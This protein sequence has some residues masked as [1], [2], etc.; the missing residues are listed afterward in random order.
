MG[1]NDNALVPQDTE[2]GLIS[3]MAAFSGLELM[4]EYRGSGLILGLEGLSPSD[5]KLPRFRIMQPTSQEVA[6][7]KVQAGTF[8]NPV[9]GEAV[10]EL[11]CT[12]LINSKS[13]VM[14]EKLFKRGDKPMCS[15]FD[16][17][18]SSDG[19]RKC[20]KCNS[21]NGTTKVKETLSHHVIC[22]MYGLE[23][24]NFQH[25]MDSLSELS[26]QG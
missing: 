8:Y 9:T 5:L 1:K 19:K 26:S 10:K 25:Q 13:M 15:S 3:D 21:L 7:Q 17:E 23:L 18:T 20:A 11:S 22:L 2:I 24:A 12:L 16:G 6:Q 14:W 4:S